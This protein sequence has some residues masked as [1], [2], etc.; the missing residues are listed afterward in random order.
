M[1]DEESFVYGDY[2]RKDAERDLKKGSVTVYSS[3]PIKQG[4]FVSTSKI[5]AKDYAGGKDIYSAE[6]SLD[7]VA[8]INGDE[9]QYAKRE[10]TK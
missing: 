6:V 8:W 5:M 1:K 3:H 2:S 10:K 4:T 9:G 7:E